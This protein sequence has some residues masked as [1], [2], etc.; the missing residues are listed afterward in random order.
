MFI[1]LKILIHCLKI[2]FITNRD[3]ELLSTF[4][5]ESVFEI[6]L[7]LNNFPIVWFSFFTCM[8]FKQEDNKTFSLFMFLAAFYSSFRIKTAF[9]PNTHG[10]NKITLFPQ[11]SIKTLFVWSISFNWSTS[12]IAFTETNQT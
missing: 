11:T 7:H 4:F 9:I 8:K 2:H 3:F 1:S 12:R 6:K 5:L 10:A